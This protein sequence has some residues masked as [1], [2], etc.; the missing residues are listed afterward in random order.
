MA[1]YV[2][3]DELRKELIKSISIG[4]LTPN[5]LNMLISMVDNIQRGFPYVRSN[6]K[7][8]VRSTAILIVLERWNR[9][10][11]VKENAFSYFT[12]IIKNAIYGGWNEL[13]GKG[14]TKGITVVSYSNI[15]DESV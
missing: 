10:N 13:Q 6:D 5:C 4:E 3:N 9:Y 7:E 2:K 14:Y 11:P 8:D 12:Q 15:F 1:I